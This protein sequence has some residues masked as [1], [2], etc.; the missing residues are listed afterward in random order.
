MLQ[1]WFF[2]FYYTITLV[3]WRVWLRTGHGGFE[4]FFPTDAAA[5]REE[6]TQGPETAVQVEK[7]RG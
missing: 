6:V 2:F 5:S 7:T 3:I 1:R 4:S